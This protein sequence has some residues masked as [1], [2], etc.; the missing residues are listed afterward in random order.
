MHETRSKQIQDALLNGPKPAPEKE[1]AV[2]Q[3]KLVLSELEHMGLKPQGEYQAPM[4][5]IPQHLKGKS[6]FPKI[7]SRSD[8]RSLHRSAA[9]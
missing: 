7:S 1:Y 4:H 5:Q 6:I 9:Y 2:Y 8:I 3:G